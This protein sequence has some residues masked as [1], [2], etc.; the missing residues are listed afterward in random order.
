MRLDFV[1]LRPWSLVRT[2]FLWTSDTIWSHGFFHVHSRQAVEE[3]DQQIIEKATSL[4]W[5][6]HS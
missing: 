5:S 6:Q 1:T 3:M 4:D 2:S